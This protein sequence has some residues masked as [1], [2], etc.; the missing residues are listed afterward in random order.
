MF[1]KHL[2]HFNDKVV[3]LFNSKNIQE[4][5]FMYIFTNLTFQL[6]AYLSQ[7]IQTVQT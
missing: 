3:F 7:Q 4:M 2:V 5:F 6:D 1:N